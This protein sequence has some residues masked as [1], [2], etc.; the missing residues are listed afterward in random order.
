MVFASSSSVY[1]SSEEYPTVEDQKVAPISPYGVTKAACE[2]LIDVYV[3]QFHV[4][5]VSLRYFTV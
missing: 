5:A 2:A 3:S 1:G 4:R